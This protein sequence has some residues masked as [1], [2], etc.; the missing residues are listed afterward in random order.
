MAAIPLHITGDVLRWPRWYSHT[1]CNRGWPA[2][3]KS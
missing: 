1:L 2:A 3:C